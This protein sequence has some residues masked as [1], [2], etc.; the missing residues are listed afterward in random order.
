MKRALAA[1]AG[2]AALLAGCSSGPKKMPSS[3]LYLTERMATVFLQQGNAMEAENAFRKVLGDDPDNAEMRDGHGLSLLMLGRPK[4]ALA[5]FD[6]A[7]KIAPK[8]SYLNNR[9]VARMELGDLAGAEADF[10]KAYQSPNMGDRQSA[11][12]NL[13]RARMRRGLPGE[14][15][16]AFTRAIA[17]APDS[18]EALMARGE[19]REARKNEKG[20]I[21]DYLA[22]LKIKSE[23]L[24]AMLHVGMG[25]MAL[26]NR[27]LGVRYLRRVTELAPD[28]PQAARARLILGEGSSATLPE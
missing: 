3:E 10:Q 24:D 17:I 23:S 7:L 21:E 11:L 28:S 12:I 5:E 15:E 13:G 4:E 19:A 18:Y 16:E 25:L 2:A 22:A 9:G 6:R 1:A 20:A 27:D 26:D 8:E 14:A